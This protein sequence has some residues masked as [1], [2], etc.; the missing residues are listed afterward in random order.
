MAS[1]RLLLRVPLARRLGR[2]DPM[3][4]VRRRSRA[5][6]DLPEPPPGSI[7]GSWMS[8]A[9]VDRRLAALGVF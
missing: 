3:E 1:S 8:P 5:V 7:G 4:E 6:D 2:E 9:E